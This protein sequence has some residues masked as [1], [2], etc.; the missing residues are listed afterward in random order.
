M[1]KT[2]LAVSAALLIAPTTVLAQDIQVV[3]QVGPQVQPVAINQNSNINAAGVIQIGGNPNAT[4][5]QTGAANLAAVGQAG[6]S[7]SSSIAQTGL[8]NG[9]LVTQVGG[10]NTSTIVQNSP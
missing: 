10:L 1:R 4:V 3:V 6:A 9:A 7:T 2:L 5:A 8:L